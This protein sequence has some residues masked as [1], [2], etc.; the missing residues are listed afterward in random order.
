MWMM[1]MLAFISA[2][3]AI[4]W[5][6]YLEFPR[7]SV[8]VSHIELCRLWRKGEET[9]VWVVSCM[10]RNLV[11]DM[12]AAC[13]A[14]E[15]VVFYMK[16]GRR[17]MSM[18]RVMHLKESCH[19]YEC[20]VLQLW[21][22]RVVYERRAERRV[23]PRCV[24]IAVC[25]SVLQCVALCW[26]VLQCVAVCCS[27]LQCVEVCCS[28]LQCVD[29]DLFTCAKPQTPQDWHDLFFKRDTYAVT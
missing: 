12:N 11:T 1:T 14:Y 15:W 17:D 29:I 22:S 21:M 3:R 26:S 19:Q 24:C 13:Y 28:V 2:L 9:C 8:S 5:E 18:S 27:V 7:V 4:V 6:L 16:E 23:P 10:W 20:S 25:C